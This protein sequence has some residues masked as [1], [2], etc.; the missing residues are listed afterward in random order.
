MPDTTQRLTRTAQVVA[1]LARH[2]RILT[3][4]DWSHAPPVEPT[5]AD[6]SGIAEAQAFAADLESLGP[7]FIK[8]GQSLSTRPD[9][10]PAA[11]IDALDRIQD[12]VAPVDTTVVEKIVEEELG[13]KIGR[14]FAS[15]DPVPLAA[16]S[17]AQVHR[18]VLR[19]GR[20]VA[21]KVQRPGMDPAIRLDLE[22]PAR[23][24]PPT[25]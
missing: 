3:G 12:E 20:E 18:A 17:L 7:A 25:R 8:L 4:M 24:A 2:R 19:D 6:A 5:I 14:L 15:F 22:V 11:Y 9:L 23:P 1:R 21:V 16:A 13:A 10:V